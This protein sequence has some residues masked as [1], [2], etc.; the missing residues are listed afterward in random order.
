MH[1]W[2][3]S[4][5][6]SAYLYLRPWAA[7]SLAARLSQS[8]QFLSGLEFNEEHEA[9]IEVI[10]SVVPLARGAAAEAPS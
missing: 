8:G 5:I 3:L 4:M 1:L 6:N 7:P 10:T 2:R 9:D